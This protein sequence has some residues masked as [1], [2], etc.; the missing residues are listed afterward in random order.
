MGPNVKILHIIEATFAGVGR[1]VLDLAGHQGKSGHEVHVVYSPIRESESFAKERAELRGVTWHSMEIDRSPS[2]RDLRAL[3]RINSIIQ[4]FGPEVI[5]GHSTKGGLLARTCRTRGAKVAYTPNALYTMSPGLSENS[6]R[7]VSLLEKGLSKR[8]D[9]FIAVSPEERDHA[10]ELG[11]IPRS[12]VVIPNGI[13]APQRFDKAQ[14]RAE[15]GVAPA[16]PLLGFVG[17]LDEQKAPERLLD[18]LDAV[19]KSEPTAQLL[20]VGDG[21]DRQSLEA[22]VKAREL[23]GIAFAGTQPGTWAMCSFD[24]FVLPSR[25]EGFPYVLIEAAHLRIPIV[26]S[27]ESNSSYLAEKYGAMSNVEGRDA[28][29]FAEKVLAALT[30]Q[31]AGTESDLDEFLLCNMAAAVERAYSL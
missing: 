9:V 27:K 19:R 14:V 12:I 16:G 6:H 18:I 24:V 31:G 5:H 26:A 25:Y 13:V 10:A 3:N 7:L 30:G 17:R 21:P 2:A 1:H 28:D 20:I 4:N 11:L 8:T 15:L 23:E 22:L 29:G